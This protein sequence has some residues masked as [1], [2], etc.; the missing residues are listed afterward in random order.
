DAHAAESSGP[1]P[2]LPNCCFCLRLFPNEPLLLRHIQTAHQFSWI[3][4][5]S[6]LGAL[7]NQVDQASA[8][9]SSM[10][11]F[12]GDPA[13]VSKKGMFSCPVCQPSEPSDPALMLSSELELRRHMLLCHS[14]SL[15]KDQSSHC[16]SKSMMQENQHLYSDSVHFPDPQGSACHSYPNQEH[17]CQLCLARFPDLQQLEMHLQISH[18]PASQAQRFHS[19]DSVI[20]S[21]PIP[22]SR[23]STDNQRSLL[24]NCL[25][26][27]KC[28][29][30]HRDRSSLLCHTLK[31]HPELNELNICRLCDRLFNNNV[32]LHRHLKK[33][34]GLSHSGT[35]K[36]P[37]C[38]AW[39]PS[40]E[41]ASIH[42]VTL[43]TGAL[44]VHCPFCGAGFQGMHGMYNHVRLHHLQTESYVCPECQATFTGNRALSDHARKIHGMTAQALRESLH[45]ANSTTY[46]CPFCSTTLSRTYEL[47]MH[48]INAHSDPLLPRRCHICLQA[49]VSNPILKIHLAGA[50]GIELDEG[51]GED[52]PEE[53]VDEEDMDE[54]EVGQSFLHQQQQQQQHHQS[55]HHILQ[56]QQ[57]QQHQSLQVQ[58]GQQLQQNQQLC[59]FQQEQQHH[60]LKHQHQQQQAQQH[61]NQHCLLQQ[62]QTQQQQEQHCLLQQQQ[63]EQHCLLQQPQQQELLHQ[64]QTVD[65]FP[66]FDESHGDQVEDDHALKEVDD[67]RMEDGKFSH[68]SHSFEE[69]DVLETQEAGR[70]LEE[71]QETSGIN[72]LDENSQVLSLPMEQTAVSGQMFSGCTSL[73]D[74]VQL[75]SSH[76]K[77]LNLS[78]VDYLETLANDSIAV[79]A[80]VVATGAI[81]ASKTQI[82]RGQDPLEL[83]YQFE[84]D[85]V[86]YQLAPA[87]GSSVHQDEPM[88]TASAI[89][90]GLVYLLQQ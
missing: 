21:M 58:Q 19:A 31:V 1:G 5:Q 35:L 6:L 64:P 34:H 45:S 75:L 67:E 27:S 63:Q 26:C 30:A 54:D 80:D 53:E 48:V 83:P 33:A 43:H 22:H 50:H 65:Q 56:Q 84:I 51:L 47:A 49:F 69:Q 39:L 28:N 52:I 14:V 55:Q 78:G 7:H 86:L 12:S 72:C 76:G 17:V 11:L 36:C 62:H 38:P 60:I 85:G 77:D 10:W 82:I 16:F 4:S 71:L 9:C 73:E 23:F 74:E 46:C 79:G 81:A 3:Q 66:D 61:Q 15:D 2:G 68:Q 20:E 18:K 57:N 24:A 87:I 44:P 89:T 90:E 42:R 29:T 70:F 8:R 32:G 40:M 13:V 37:F 41:L 25:L 59:M 88:D